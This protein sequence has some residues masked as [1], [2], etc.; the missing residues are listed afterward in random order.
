[1]IE[2]KIDKWL[3][4]ETFT[5]LHL[6]T[7]FSIKDGMIS[8]PKLVQKAKEDGQK[9]VAISDHGSLSG[10]WQLYSECKKNDITPIF[11]CEVYTNPHRNM[12]KNRDSFIEN[13]SA[14]NKKIFRKMLRKSFH[15][16]LLS[17]NQ[18]G[19]KNLL[20]IQNDANMNGFYYHSNT[21][22]EF[23]FE[24]SKGIIA[25]TACFAGEIPQLL[26]NKNYNLAKHTAYEF[27]EVFGENF[28]IELMI[29]NF[30][31][32]KELNEML[33]KLAQDCN[34][35]T[36]ITCDSHYMNKEDYELQTLILNQETKSGNTENALWEFDATDLYV[37]TPH[38]MWNDFQKQH[39]SDVF[40]DK[41]YIESFENIENIISKI[42][43]IILESTPRLPEYKNEKKELL[44]RAIEGLN[45]KISK[46]IIPKDKLKI[47]QER[48]A[49]EFDVIT[50]M[51]AA[52]YM[53][54]FNDVIKFCDNPMNPELW[55]NKQIP[56]NIKK[57]IPKEGKILRGT[58]RGSVGGSLI[59]Y[60]L[61]I[62]Q[63]VDPIKFDLLFERFLDI[64]RIPKMK[65]DL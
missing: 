25:S 18:D 42:E 12:I 24:N 52:S 60:L 30:P 64:N 35:K 20:K 19:F 58:G 31:K 36:I 11:G 65:L 23:I 27:K 14:E 9:A 41:V 21:D 39:K 55:N 33:I 53:L 28:Y 2:F 15:L 62:T 61:E 56:E 22:N 29:N 49:F 26:Y 45:K 8:I 43:N 44:N 16:L 40:T 50:K 34:I 17:Y 57:L 51:H 1:M 47:Y 4:P 5:H 38:E 37:K 32:Q 3:S 10:C 63:G 6:H 54:L 48:L 13:V 46:G 59:A 7:I